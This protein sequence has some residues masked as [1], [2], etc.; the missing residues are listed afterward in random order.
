M[1]FLRPGH[2]KSQE[3]FFQLQGLP[4]GAFSLTTHKGL[5]VGAFFLTVGLPVGAPRKM[6]LR[7]NPMLK[8]MLLRANP[9]E[10]VAPTGKPHSIGFARRSNAVTYKRQRKYYFLMNLGLQFPV[11]GQPL[12]GCS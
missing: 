1:S 10:E 11:S 9:P 5:P 8:K 4:V 7:A 6:L 12:A 2:L 3:H